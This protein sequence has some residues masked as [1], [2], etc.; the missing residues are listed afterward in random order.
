[1]SF[2]GPSRAKPIEGR[3]PTKRKARA[4]TPLSSGGAEESRAAS[5]FI[6]SKMQGE[7]AIKYRKFMVTPYPWRDR[8]IW[9][10]RYERFSY[11]TSTSD[12]SNAVDGFYACVSHALDVVDAHYISR[13][14]LTLMMAKWQVYA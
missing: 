8:V 3:H 4:K 13:K 9:H 6:R 1:M 7:Y 5:E 14:R 2:I 12:P 10:V 11:H